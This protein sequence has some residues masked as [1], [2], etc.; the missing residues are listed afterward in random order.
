MTHHTHSLFGF[1]FGLITIKL[2]K[3]FNITSLHLPVTSSLFNIALI[4]FYIATIIGALI[5]DIDHANSKAGKKLWFISKPLKLFGIKHRGL[6]H[7]IL[8][9]ILFALLTQELVKLKLISNIIWSGLIIGYFSHLITDMLNVQGI[10]LFYP[11]DKRFKFHLNITTG[12]WSEHLIFLVAFTIITL[13]FFLE[14]DYI[15]FQLHN[16]P[17]LFN[18]N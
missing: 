7:S 5:P 3:I 13:L 1:V 8:G 15:N 17:Q 6:T 4:E 16:L 14:Q 2:V 18:L 12:S 10:P 9:L 11:N